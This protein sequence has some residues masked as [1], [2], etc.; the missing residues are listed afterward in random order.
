MKFPFL[1]SLGQRVNVPERD[2]VQGVIGLPKV[3][4]F[5]LDND[6]R[7]KR[8]P[9][10]DDD[11]LPTNFGR[12]Y[13]LRYLDEDGA[14]VGA[15]FEER[16]LRDINPTPA[17]IEKQEE[18]ARVKLE[19]ITRAKCLEEFAVHENQWALER[20]SLERRLARARS[21][22]RKVGIKRKKR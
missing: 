1:F 11:E 6:T 4:A 16:R 21:A 13:F 20:K 12:Q 18:T 9:I 15:W 22:A 17:E 2:G 8:T 3:E 5:R 19:G 7:T 10:M 14:V